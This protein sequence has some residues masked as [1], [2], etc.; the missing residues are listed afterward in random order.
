MIFWIDK[1]AKKSQDSCYKNDRSSQCPQEQDNLRDM[2][3]L[4][5]L[6][7]GPFGCLL[8][9]HAAIKSDFEK[10]MNKLDQAK[11]QKFPSLSSLIIQ[12]KFLNEVLIF[13]R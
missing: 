4:C 5:L 13:D 8:L 7:N 12:I 3:T 11:Q 9:L 2:S 10:I 1:A 6:K